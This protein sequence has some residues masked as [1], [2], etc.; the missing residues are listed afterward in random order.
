[1]ASLVVHA[2]GVTTIQACSRGHRHEVTTT[3]PNMYTV[4]ARTSAEGNALLCA[5]QIRVVEAI[6]VWATKDRSLAKL[7]CDHCS[8]ICDR[9]S[10]IYDRCSFI[11]DHCPFTM[12]LSAV[13]FF[14]ITH[15]AGVEIEDLHE[16]LTHFVKFQNPEGGASANSKT[17]HLEPTL[18]KDEKFT[19]P[20]H[21]PLV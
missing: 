6:A 2:L 13:S 17:L 20:N 19:A 7:T 10:F 4:V 3:K 14:R 11:C 8:F 9:C 12:V 1:M 21:K 18:C 16:F 15:H 5:A